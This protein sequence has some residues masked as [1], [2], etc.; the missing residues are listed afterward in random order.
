MSKLEVMEALKQMTTDERLEI[1]EAASRLLRQDLMPRRQSISLAAAAEIMRRHY[2]VG[3]DLAM[4][5]DQ[6][7]EEFYEYHDYA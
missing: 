7:T 1:I 3:T 4:I 6:D 5:T 2:E